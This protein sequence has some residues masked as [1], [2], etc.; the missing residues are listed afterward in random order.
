MRDKKIPV[1]RLNDETDHGGKVISASGSKILG[2][3]AALVGDMTRCPKC[4]GDFS[5]QSNGNPNK[6][7][8]RSYAYHGDLTDCGAKLISSFK[9]H[10][11]EPRTST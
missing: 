3:A 1:V 8:G 7:M 2:V 9:E 4:N 5:I 6:C 11:S 10:E